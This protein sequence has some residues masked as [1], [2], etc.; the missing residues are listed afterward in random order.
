VVTAA[1]ELVPILVDCSKPG[2]HEDLQTRYGVRGYPTVLFLDSNGAKVEELASR[3]AAGV[4]DQ[5]QKVAKAHSRPVISPMTL[6]EGTTIAREQRKLL[7]VVFVEAEGHPE[8]NALVDLVLSPPL[9]AV[10]GRFHW[11]RRPAVGD[12]KRL[13]EEA[14][15]LGAKAKGVTLIVLDPWAEGDD[16]ELKKLT[17]FKSLRRD[18]EKVLQEA[19][20]RGHPPSGSDEAPKDE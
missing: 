7:A 6:E 10:R 20:K 12:N 5:M 19:Q 14:K 4:R 16:Q 2:Q 8:G 3:D 11:V 1:R 18:L 13:T 15:G 17:A 9:E